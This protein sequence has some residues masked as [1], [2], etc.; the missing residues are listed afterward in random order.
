[1]G[2]FLFVF[3]FCLFPQ[4][5]LDE[6]YCPLFDDTFP[7]SVTADL[8]FTLKVRN[9]F[10]PFVGPLFAAKQPF[11]FLQLSLPSTSFDFF[12]A[13]SVLSVLEFLSFFPPFFP[14]LGLI[15]FSP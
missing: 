8:F 3:F 2:G 10:P 1:V 11:P 15:L 12:A 13:F 7:L 14:R 6:A 5:F 4:R 9:F